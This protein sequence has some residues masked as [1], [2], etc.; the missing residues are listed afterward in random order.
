MT[1]NL[2]LLDRIILHGNL[3]KGGALEDVILT[4]AFRKE[5][6]ITPKEVIDYKLITLPNG[7]LQWDDE[8]IKEGFNYEI[9]ANLIAIIHKWFTSIIEAK[10]MHEDFIDLYEKVK[11][12]L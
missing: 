5:I 8:N 6:E 10:T 7:N 1:I 11:A 12:L 4:K 2:S 3:Q 9:G